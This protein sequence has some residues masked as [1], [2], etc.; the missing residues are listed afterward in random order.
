[1]RKVKVNEFKATATQYEYRGGF[2]V[3]CKMSQ[4]IMH[5][6]NS[7]VDDRALSAMLLDFVGMMSQR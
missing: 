5:E 6:G 7:P 4:T 3:E 2:V 1:M